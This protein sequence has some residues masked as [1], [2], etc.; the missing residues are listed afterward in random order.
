MKE[1]SVQKRC[2]PRRSTG[3]EAATEVLGTPKIKHKS[4]GI[5]TGSF[6][7]A[8]RAKRQRQQQ[9]WTQ[10][11]LSSSGSAAFSSSMDMAI[12]EGLGVARIVLLGELWAFGTTFSSRPSVRRCPKRGMLISHNE[13]LAKL[14]QEEDLRL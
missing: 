11:K 13:G 8:R 10:Q 12:W 1:A 9:E 2:I 5:V 6:R 7:S 3:L 4:G 14:P